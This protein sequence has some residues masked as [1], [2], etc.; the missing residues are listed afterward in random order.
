MIFVDLSFMFI[1]VICWQTTRNDGNSDSDN[2]T[3]DDSRDDENLD[4]D[5]NDI[6]DNDKTDD[7]RTDTNEENDKTRND[8]LRINARLNQDENVQNVRR[9][10]RKHTQRFKINPD[11]I[12]ECDD[13]NDEDY[14]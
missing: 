11:E 13:E 3:H 8:E 6:S 14:K 5:D 10:E 4:D 7:S 1:S 12:G 2:E 9:S